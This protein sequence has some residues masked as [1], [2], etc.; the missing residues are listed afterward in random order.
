M[1]GQKT[2]YVFPIK[3]E[4]QGPGWYTCKNVGAICREK[5]GWIFYPERIWEDPPSEPFKTLKEAKAE[6]ER[7]DT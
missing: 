4:M 2:G 1:T 5:K 3:W 7:S 6:A